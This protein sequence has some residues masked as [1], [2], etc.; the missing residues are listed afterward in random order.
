MKLLVVCD[1][2]EE[3]ES[4]SRIKKRMESNEFDHLLVSGDLS[5]NVSFVE[6][7][8]SEFPDAF[9]VPGNWDSKAVG[10]IMATGRHY[11]HEKRFEL[12]DGFN[13]VGFGYSNITP[14]HTFGELSEQDI[15]A[16]MSKLN[17]D[18]NT[19]LMMHCP[20]K[21]YFDDALGFH[22]GSES[23]L[24]IITEKKPFA[25][26]FGHIHDHKGTAKLGNTHLVKIPSAK[27]M[28]GCIVTIDKRKLKAE[29]VV[30]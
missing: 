18:E 8:V 28:Q 4:C 15:Y 25:A 7:F 5:R 21:G 12:K 30:L 24:R 26:F 2:H 14:F 11:A 22:T 20:P 1:I 10:E 3:E 16:R 29:F 17:I 23:I 6:E 27:N 13:L 9:I 19:L